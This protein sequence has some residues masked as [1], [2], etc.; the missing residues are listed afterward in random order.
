MRSKVKQAICREL[1]KRTG[2]PYGLVSDV[3]RAWA[4]G[5][6]AATPIRLVVAE[7][8]G[9]TDVGYLP[10][11]KRGF[12]ASLEAGESF[13]S[14]WSRS[15]DEVLGRIKPIIEESYKWTQEL[16]DLA[17]IDTIP[18][19]RGMGFNHS[20]HIAIPLPDP[21][22]HAPFLYLDTHRPEGKIP[23]LGII[24]RVTPE[25]HKILGVESWTSAPST[26]YSFARA[27]PT[28]ADRYEEQ[29]P[30]PASLEET[31]R[32]YALKPVQVPPITDEERE[33]LERFVERV[34]FGEGLTQLQT[35]KPEAI[36][37]FLFGQADK[38][39]VVSTALTGI[40]CL[41]ESEFLIG[42]M[43]RNALGI[44]LLL[45]SVDS[46][47]PSPNALFDDLAGTRD[48]LLFTGSVDDEVRRPDILMASVPAYRLATSDSPIAWTGHAVPNASQPQAIE[49][50]GRDEFPVPKSYTSTRFP[51]TGKV[52][53][54]MPDESS[55]PPSKWPS[56]VGRT[57]ARN[58]YE[59]SSQIDRIFSAWQMGKTESISDPLFLL[60]MEEMVNTLY[61]E[62]LSL[63]NPWRNKV[64]QARSRLSAQDILGY[65]NDSKDDFIAINKHIDRI[66][67]DPRV[68]DLG[69]AYIIFP[70]PSRE[71]LFTFR[72]E[73]RSSDGKLRGGEIP[74]EA[75]TEWSW[76]TFS[77]DPDR[78][79]PPPLFTAVTKRSDFDYVP[80]AERVKEG[81]ALHVIAVDLKDPG[82]MYIPMAVQPEGIYRTNKLLCAAV[83][84]PR[85]AY[86]SI[87]YG[88]DLLMRRPVL[89]HNFETAQQINRSKLT[90]RPISILSTS[91]RKQQLPANR[92]YI[93]S[94]EEA[95]PGVTVHE[96]PRGGLFYVP[97]ER[98]EPAALS[99]EERYSL[100]LDQLL[101]GD[102]LQ[103]IEIRR[104]FLSTVPDV[105]KSV[106]ASL[107][108][109]YRD[110]ELFRDILWDT[111]LTTLTDNQVEE[112][113]L[114]P[115]EIDSIKTISDDIRSR[116]KQAVSREIAKRLGK[117]SVE[118]ASAFLRAW[119]KGSEPAIP[120][121][122][123]VGEWRG[124][125]VPIHP[126]EIES[127]EKNPLHP[128]NEVIGNL[129][130]SV[131]YSKEVLPIIYEWTQD[132]LE[133]AGIEELRLA[134]GLEFSDRTYG[135]V[136]LPDPLEHVML[137]DSNVKGTLVVGILGKVNPEAYKDLGVESWS[138]DMDTLV[139]FSAQRE[140]PGRVPRA[141]RIPPAPTS[142][143]ETLRDPN[144]K[145][146]ILAAKED[147]ELPYFEHFA[148][149]L[150]VPE[151][152][153][154]RNPSRPIAMSVALL[155]TSKRADILST[156]LTGMGC[157][158]EH[159]V[160]LLK[161]PEDT[162]GVWV[163]ND[164]LAAKDRP[165]NAAH[166]IRK[167]IDPRGQWSGSL[168]VLA[169]PVPAYSLAR[170]DNPRAWTGYVVPGIEKPQAVEFLPQY[171]F[172]ISPSYGQ[173]KFPKAA[174]FYIT[175]LLPGWTR[176][177][178]FEFSFT[179][180]E[181]SLAISSGWGSFAR[182][183]TSYPNTLVL[184]DEVSDALLG[185]RLELPDEIR[186]LL[187]SEKTEVFTR[188][189]REER[190]IEKLLKFN[191]EARKIL[192]EVDREH[193]GVAF[194]AF[195]SP[196]Q[197]PFFEVDLEYQDISGN[198]FGGSVPSQGLSSWGFINFD[199]SSQEEIP[200]PLLVAI[201][202]P[203]E[204]YLLKRVRDA[205]D[206]ANQALH[207]VSVPLSHEGMF[208]IPDTSPDYIF[209]IRKIWAIPLL[210][211]KS[212]YY[213][214]EKEPNSGT[215]KLVEF[216]P[217][218]VSNW[219]YL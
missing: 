173:A 27:Y 75:L 174:P 40:G 130:D 116:I 160:I 72:E 117:Y 150:S 193:L 43:P 192:Q 187:A 96:G 140:L 104:N 31:F 36:S 111:W 77:P 171:R 3:L 48:T 21:V 81:G 5:D 18:L 82:L 170:A 98:Y 113:G 134:R 126:E 55:L 211:P 194:T 208:F 92:V 44:W 20:G 41:T 165:V 58:W 93:E 108:R 33:R 45:S 184:L 147:R 107:L 175:D 101:K 210:P 28:W 15:I 26:S 32:D 100:T 212:A 71:P 35:V 91:V 54:L 122:L 57:E 178:I 191:E 185:R 197:E 124:V 132:V 177:G 95:P 103:G 29:I 123:A 159:E 64:D 68:G 213:L 87:V 128:L 10:E 106:R 30:R 127:Y 206:R 8:Q 133:K 46:T 137:L 66:R 73:Y 156:A 203:R 59:V 198:L 23:Y 50:M 205:A 176:P 188:E 143:E 167:L 163:L 89:F 56:R 76:L 84:P 149:Q 202:N 118:H 22:A 157:M 141:A 196:R 131:E 99:A 201:E 14:D 166:T 52:D 182:N 61:G 74:T 102:R 172:P 90:S 11:I 70:Y 78:P 6:E 155:G 62:R 79:F 129:R 114:S 4:R 121:R 109:D 39:N 214:V 195:A 207:M 63:P 138:Y 179:W 19:I 152:S 94:P 209:S 115:G 136:P 38:A 181:A 218:V 105:L 120:I 135:A 200:V 219:K 80:A 215:A 186:T 9:Q 146:Q 164:Y 110:K 119:A 189:L 148:D 158:P 199:F 24:G 161:P 13:W 144:Q 16:L 83:L 204:E 162:V 1:A 65:Y 2:Q 151:M 42:E 67:K 69:V 139:L 97:S 145:V 125:P 142:L 217:N 47:G 51:M 25:S 86:Y 153:P 180:H 154:F 12:K 37:I 216:L 183:L 190:I 169:A 49:F 60:L 53:Q 34:G 88:D 85:R 112:L 168:D 7:L 17:G